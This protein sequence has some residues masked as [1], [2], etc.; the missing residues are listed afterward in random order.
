MN[1][2][3]NGSVNETSFIFKEGSAIL[4]TYNP[5]IEEAKSPKRTLFSALVRTYIWFF[6]QAGIYKLFQ[7]IL[8]FTSP[9]LL[10]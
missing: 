2:V 8:T 4:A 3:A 9:Q 10:K 5:G 7:D 1:A 6:L